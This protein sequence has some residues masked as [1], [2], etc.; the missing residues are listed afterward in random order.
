MK[1]IK[2]KARMQFAYNNEAVLPGQVIEMKEEDVEKYA[3]EVV[4]VNKSS[5]RAPTT[6]KKPKS[7]M[8]RR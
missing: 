1:L 2:V 5:Y 6:K 8:T 3:Q 4:V 7:V